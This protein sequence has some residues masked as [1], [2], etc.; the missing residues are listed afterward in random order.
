MPFRQVYTAKTGEILVDHCFIFASNTVL[1]ES[2]FPDIATVFEDR[3][4]IEYRRFL[5]LSVCSNIAA[6]FEYRFVPIITALFEITAVFEYRLPPVI[7]PKTIPKSAQWGP[8]MT[9]RHL[10]TN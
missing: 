2:R 5:R 9:P 3:R 8:K 6:F 10:K 4:F 1:F 7:R